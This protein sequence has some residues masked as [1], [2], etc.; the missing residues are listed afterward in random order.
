MAQ[1][2]IVQTQTERHVEGADTVVLMIHGIIE[3]PAQFEPLIPII[4]KTGCSAVSILLPGHGKTGSEFSKNGRKQWTA[5]ISRQIEL[6]RQR[7]QNIIL[8]GHSM[9]CLLSANSCL[10]N[11]SGIRGLFCIA[12]P[13][14]I[15]L[16]ARGIINAV[17]VALNRVK[18]DD[19]VSTAAR[20]AYSISQTPLYGYAAWLPRYLDLFR[21]CR[22]VRSRLHEVRVPVCIVHSAEDEFVSK[23][24]LIS[25]QKAL[26]ANLIEALVLKHSGHFYY[27]EEDRKLLAQA[28]LRLLKSIRT[29]KC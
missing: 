24:S 6:L 3:G 26:G 15:R 12:M 17:R 9:G 18:E 20:D 22:S 14:H 10:D 21:L 8:V 29:E 11:P 1:K 16:T 2:E 7:Y 13:L 23:R 5:Y 25:A 4:N 27:P 19:P 28:L